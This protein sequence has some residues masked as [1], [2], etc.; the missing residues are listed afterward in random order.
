MPLP[1]RPRMPKALS[2]YVFLIAFLAPI[3]HSAPLQVLGDVVCK[4]TTW[5]D[6]L[7]FLLANFVAHT[8]TIPQTPGI[9]WYISIQWCLIAF[10]LPFFTLS[11]S[12]GK[13]VEHFSRGGNDLRN[14]LA[15]GA[16]VIVA[17]TSK[18]RPDPTSVT[19]CEA[20]AIEK[21]R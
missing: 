18:W 11:S 3:A 8:A 12:I 9:K 21:I 14:A 5:H 15:A 16:I 4:P 6:V 13:L 20:R 1:M 10:L 2:I 17:R 19:I 7:V